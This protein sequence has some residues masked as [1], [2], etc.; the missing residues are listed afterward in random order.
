MD[1]LLGGGVLPANFLA[2]RADILFG[3]YISGD[4]VARDET[5]V[6]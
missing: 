1:T 3:I 2:K 4:N 6:E 5:E